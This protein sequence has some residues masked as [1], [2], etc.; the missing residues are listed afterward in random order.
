MPAAVANWVLPRVKKEK[1]ALLFL[2]A[3]AA[4]LSSFMA[5]PVVVTTV[6][7]V[8]DPPA[9]ILAMETGMK[10]L[11]FYWFKG[12][13]SLGTLSVACVIAALLTLLVQ[14]R[15]LNKT[16]D[17]EHVPTPM[18]TGRWRSLSSASWP[19]RSHPP[20]STRAWSASPSASSP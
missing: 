11:D 17:I 7:M 20:T 3:L 12:R 5:N 14:F 8:A 15:K 18:T 19:W 13:L 6:S 16:V 1:Y 2:C 9:L 4:A 10:F